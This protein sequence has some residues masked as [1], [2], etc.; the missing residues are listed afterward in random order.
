MAQQQ[1][2]SLAQA[3]QGGLIDDIDVEIMDAVFCEYDYAGSIDH[4]ILALGLSLRDGEGKTYDQYYSAGE[5]T[6]FVP[7]DDGAMA[8]PVA[9]KQLLT[10]TCNAWKFLMSLIE[11]GFP[12]A[13]LETGNIKNLIGMQV[14]VKQF[15][16]PKRQGLI[17]GGKNPDREPTVLLVTEI[18]A[19]PGQV[20]APAQ[21]PKRAGL[22]GAGKPVGAR[23]TLGAAQPAKPGLGARPAATAGKPSAPARTSP[24][25]P[26]LGARPVNGQ[27]GAS[28][29]AQAGGSD[30]DKL[31]A[32]MI[33]DQI[34]TSS[35][36]SITKKELST[37]AFKVA[38]EMVAS[39][40][41]EAKSKTRIVQLVFQD[42]FLHELASN[43]QVLYDGATLQAI[44]QAA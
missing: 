10:D 13:A 5:L 2:I 34:L 23:P 37:A 24:S 32:T 29:P 21:P 15:G 11:C 39:Q 19:M 38:G 3:S 26:K 12:V 4:N 28:A 41:L 17:R 25:K 44:T 43:G 40:A 42:A 30:E 27:A 36:G 31:L 9:D 20:Q 16:Q 18:L 7:S 1:G 22:A 14:H 8:V 33:V 35:G 6:Y